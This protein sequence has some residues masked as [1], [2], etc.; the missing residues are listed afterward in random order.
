MKSLAAVAVMLAWFSCG[1]FAQRG[2]SHGGFSGSHAGFSA[3]ASGV[4]SHGAPAFQGGF[5]APHSGFARPASPGYAGPARF[6]PRPSSY[7]IRGPRPGGGPRMPSFG[8]SA[9]RAPYHAPYGWNHSHHGYH[10][11]R[12]VYVSGGWPVWGWRYPYGWGYPYLWPSIFPDTDNSQPAAN[13]YSNGLYQ[14]QPEDQAGPA[15]RESYAQR[16]DTLPAPY[17]GTQPL[18]PVSEAPVTLVFKDRRPPE[19]IHN[20]LLTAKMLT[21]LDQHRR[22]IPVDQIDLDATAKANLQAGVEFS[23]PSRSP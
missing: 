2:G 3:R 16:P 23:V 11:H 14:I 15:P 17:A 5:S 7:P 8:S 10:H 21:V 13:D 19:Q 18:P 12:V 6:T 22:S 4:S 20:Y 9:H 1:A